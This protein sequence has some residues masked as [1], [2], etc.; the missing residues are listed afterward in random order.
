M[1]GRTATGGRA[2]EAAS[3]FETADF[4]PPSG[5]RVAPMQDAMGLRDLETERACAVARH[6]RPACS[7][8]CA[9]VACRGRG[10]SIS[11]STSTSG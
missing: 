1:A 3:G 10:P 8:F 7:I 4:F 2:S 6:G 11:A 9:T 5:W